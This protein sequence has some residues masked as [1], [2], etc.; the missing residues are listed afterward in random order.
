M[1]KLIKFLITLLMMLNL[2]TIK[3]KKSIYKFKF[4]NPIEC[5]FNSMQNKTKSLNIN[6]ITVML[7]F[8]I[9]DLEISLITP[10]I[11]NIK[12]N[13]M[14]NIIMMSLILMFMLLSM[15]YEIKIKSIKWK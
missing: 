4:L 14:K 13:L 7:I 15:I 9:F 3:M 1:I 11:M 5:G 8:I 10:M 2:L 6:F 12:M